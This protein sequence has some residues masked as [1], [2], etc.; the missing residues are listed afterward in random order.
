MSDK[1][2]V[3]RFIRF[4]H[5]D[6]S[7][8]GNGGIALRF[9]ID[10]ENRLLEIYPACCTFEDT[11]DKE[12]GWSLI[13]YRQRH[14]IGIVTEYEP[15]LTLVDNFKMIFSMINQWENKFHVKFDWKRIAIHDVACDWDHDANAKQVSCFDYMQPKGE[16]K[17]IKKVMKQIKKMID[18]HMSR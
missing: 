13:N 14:G 18:S 16:R 17:E 5:R 6:G 8:Q 10:H 11:F 12:R 2:E 9:M 4:L 7:I 1:I 15:S 3:T